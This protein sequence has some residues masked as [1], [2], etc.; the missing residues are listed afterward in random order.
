MKVA[1]SETAKAGYISNPTIKNLN[2]F[3]TQ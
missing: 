1:F 3:D 2:I